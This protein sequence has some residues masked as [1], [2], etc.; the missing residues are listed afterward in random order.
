MGRHFPEGIYLIWE[1][2]ARKEETAFHHTQD[3]FSS[4][5]EDLVAA[6]DHWVVANKGWMFRDSEEWIAYRFRAETPETVGPGRLAFLAAQFD[7]LCEHVFPTQASDPSW[8]GIV[9]NLGEAADSL[10][11]KLIE[12]RS[13][14]QQECF[15]CIDLGHGPIVFRHLKGL[16]GWD[17]DE[18]EFM[19]Q[20][21]VAELGYTLTVVPESDCITRR[22]EWLHC[23]SQMGMLNTLYAHEAA[24]MVDLLPETAY[25]V[26]ISSSPIPNT[27]NEL[28]DE[29]MAVTGRSERTGSSDHILAEAAVPRWDGKDLVVNGSKEATFSPSAKN[30]RPVLNTFQELGWPKNIDDPLPGGCDDPGQRLRDTVRMLNKKQDAILFESDGTGEGITWKWRGNSVEENSGSPSTELP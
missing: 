20:P 21:Q 13:Y 1:D 18:L 28:L 30:V 29:F 12:R 4:E 2:T 7:D 17:Y 5:A 6:V 11:A 3:L 22:D 10:Q 25:A 8:N 16:T 24:E 9:C 23:I 15:F 19:L 27:V 14:R 26:I